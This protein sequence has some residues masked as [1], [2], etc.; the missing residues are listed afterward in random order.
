MGTDQPD[1]DGRYTITSYGLREFDVG[2]RTCTVEHLDQDSVMAELERVWADHLRIGG[3][4]DARVHWVQP[5]PTPTGVY[6][7]LVELGRHRRPAGRVPILNNII[8]YNGEA[9]V[10][11]ERWA[12]YIPAQVDEEDLIRHLGRRYPRA[13]RPTFIL[14]ENVVITFQ[15]YQAREGDLLRTVADSPRREQGHALVQVRKTITKAT[16]K[17]TQIQF[18]DWVEVRRYDEENGQGW[19]QK[20]YIR[21]EEL[22]NHPR[23]QWSYL[24]GQPWQNRRQLPDNSPPRWQA[25]VPAHDGDDAHPHDVQGSEDEADPSTNVSPTPTTHSEEDESCAMQP[26]LAIHVYAVGCQRKTLHTEWAQTEAEFKERAAEALECRPGDIREAKI[27]PN[28]QHHDGPHVQVGVVELYGQRPTMLRDVKLILL[29]Q[30]VRIGGEPRPGT[31][32][33]AAWAPK[34]LTRQ[35]AIDLVAARWEQ[36]GATDGGHVYHCG[37]RWAQHEGT[38]DTEDGHSIWVQLWTDHDPS[39]DSSRDLRPRQDDIDTVMNDEDEREAEGGVERCDIDSD[40]SAVME[41]YLE[42]DAHEYPGRQ[43][44]VITYGLQREPI[45]RRQGQAAAPTIQAV[46]R[47]VHRQWQTLGSRVTGVALPDQPNDEEAPN[48]YVVIIALIGDPLHTKVPVLHD[49]YTS[50]NGLPATCQRQARWT[51]DT[52]RAREVLQQAGVHQMLGQ[53]WHNNNRTDG[54]Q[55]RRARQGDRITILEASEHHFALP[56]VHINIAGADTMLRELTLQQL[57]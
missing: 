10:Q 15:N 39:G 7:V 23:K 33:R 32:S 24:R 30:D 43:L 41:Q 52:L 12:S 14:G 48:P 13:T 53:V 49:I 54:W 44:T 46:R 3:G 42:Q 57:L 51:T 55:E 56:N 22:G 6:H 21:T 37:Q 11:N 20:V 40:N 31:L 26:L 18:N 28:S 8:I 50:M 34:K 16:H 2:T 5:Q 4:Q 17:T 25:E 27:I 9:V 38:H 45:G 1:L 47:E 29:E 36:D 35:K 19:H